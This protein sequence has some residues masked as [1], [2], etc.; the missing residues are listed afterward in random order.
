M[1]YIDSDN[2]LGSANGDTDDGFAIAALLKSK[3]PISEIGSVSGNTSSVQA[4]RNNEALLSVFYRTIPNLRGADCSINDSLS[5][6]RFSKDAVSDR[7][8][9]R[10]KR[11]QGK[12]RLPVWDLVPVI[13]VIHPEL[14]RIE[15]MSAEISRNTFIKYQSSMTVVQ[16]SGRAQNTPKHPQF[17]MSRPRT[18]LKYPV[19]L[20][21][22]T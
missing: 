17:G 12:N 18:E 7:W 3:I 13:Y 8:F 10:G 9:I 16:E 14:F 22:S 2:A 5:A 21:I 4:F 20:N 6:E 11:W 15:P 19:N 1:L